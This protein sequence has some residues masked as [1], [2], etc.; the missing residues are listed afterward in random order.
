M[1]SAKTG[2]RTKGTPNK[3][4]AEV[5]DM[6]R[7]A[8]DESGGVEYLKAQ[9]VQN[10]TAFLTL[11]GKLLPSQVKADVS[12]TAELDLHGWLIA[13]TKDKGQ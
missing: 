3:I 5:K 12:A 10:P 1:A 11:V 6:V 13:A 8:L 9:A 2:G 4:T 7:Q